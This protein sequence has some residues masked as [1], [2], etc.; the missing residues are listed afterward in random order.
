MYPNKANNAIVHRPLVVEQVK[1]VTVGQDG[2]VQEGVQAFGE[3]RLNFN[4]SLDETRDL[5]RKVQSSAAAPTNS[6]FRF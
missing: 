1:L 5:A 2:Q 4:P 6:G 3:H